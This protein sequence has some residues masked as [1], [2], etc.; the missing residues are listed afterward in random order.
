[1]TLLQKLMALFGAQYVTE[2][3]NDSVHVRRAERRGRYWVIEG[4]TRLGPQGKVHGYRATWEPLTP[5]IKRFYDREV[6]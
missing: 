1:M 5:S 4:G 6:V 2:V 3:W